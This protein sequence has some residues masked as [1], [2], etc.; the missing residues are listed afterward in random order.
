VQIDWANGAAGVYSGAIGRGTFGMEGTAYDKN[1]PSSTA[2]WQTS[3]HFDCAAAAPV[4][5]KP[6]KSTGHMP[7]ATPAPAA[8]SAADWVGRWDTTTDQGGHFE[9]VLTQD[10]DAIT[11]VFR[12][13]N[14]N[15]Q[16]NGTLIGTLSGKTLKYRFTQLKA[17]GLGEFS[18]ANAGQAISGEGRMN[19]A[20][21]THFA[22][23]GFKTK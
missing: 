14:G 18:I 20:D 15:P 21:K 17:A 2:T 4:E 13:L 10:G 12:D 7:A 23:W 9:L 5:P 19:D 11:G 3:H 8:A 16:Y 6:I 1:K 22:W